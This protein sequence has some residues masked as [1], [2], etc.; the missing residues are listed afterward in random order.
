MYFLAFKIT[1]TGATK[2]IPRFNKITPIPYPRISD[3]DSAY[4]MIDSDDNSG[5]IPSFNTSFNAGFSLS[6]SAIVGE[7]E[8][9]NWLKPV[10]NDMP[11]PVFI[12]WLSR[13]S[14]SNCTCG[15]ISEP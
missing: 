13:I 3:S 1:I 14:L 6:K 15:A 12:S 7:N 4:S 9:Y 11:E 10:I 2:Y 8:Y 5:V